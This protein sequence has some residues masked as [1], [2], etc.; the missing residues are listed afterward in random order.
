MMPAS[1]TNLMLRQLGKD[2]PSI[3]VIGL[4]LM[5]ASMLYGQIS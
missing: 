5:G 2:G 3:P 4:G 1:K